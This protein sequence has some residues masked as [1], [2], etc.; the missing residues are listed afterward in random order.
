[1]KRAPVWI[2]AVLL[3]AAATLLTLWL[4]PP[5]QENTPTQRTRNGWRTGRLAPAQRN[6]PVEHANH[7]RIAALA[8]GIAQILRDLGCGHLI[9]GRHSSDDWSDQSVTVCSDQLGIEYERLIALKPTHVFLQWGERELPQRLTSLAAEHNWIL[10]SYPLLTLDDIAH[11]VVAIYSAIGPDELKAMRADNRLLPGAK[12][13]ERNEVQHGLERAP[14]ALIEMLDR[15]L[16]SDPSL[17]SAGR[18]LL[19]YQGT[20]EGSVSRPAALGPGSYSHDVLV[21]IGGLSATPSGKPFMPIDAED[22]GTLKPDAIIIVRPRKAGTPAPTAPPTATE[23]IATLGAAARLS[24]PAVQNQRIALIDDSMALIPGTNLTDFADRLRS[25]LSSWAPAKPQTT[26][27][28]AQP[29]A[30]VPG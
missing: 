29:A 10:V 25:I 20:G 2:V 4:S 13:G 7:P 27:P 23:L 16:A 24:I 1:M 18:V 15:A 5:S 26:P 17:A 6:P 21:R 9:V 14:F 8:P 3:A 11:A 19:L 12:A 30:P 28:Q 22:I